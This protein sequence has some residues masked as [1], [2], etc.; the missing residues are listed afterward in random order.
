MKNFRSLLHNVLSIVM[1]MAAFHSSI[2]QTDHAKHHPKKT[3]ANADSST[4]MT[5]AAKDPGMGKK[6]AGMVG[7]MG[8]EMGEMMKEMGKP[9]SKE[10]YPSL[11]EV[12]DLSSEQ[13][14]EIKQLAN[15]QVRQGN[16]LL[17]MGLRELSGA[18]RR[19]DREAMLDANDKIQR[20][21]ILLESGLEG[22]R[23][24]SENNDP[25]VTAMQWFNREMNLPSTSHAPQ[26]HGFFGLSWFHYITML[27]LGAFAAVMIWMYFHKMQ[28]A[29][30]LI[31]K[32]TGG[33]TDKILPPDATKPTAGKGEPAAKSATAKPELAAKSSS[34]PKGEVAAKPT[35]VSTDMPPSKPNAF[36]G[37]LLVSEIFNE[38]P[39]VK[40]FRLIDSSGGKLPFNYLPGQF[41]SLT[42][43]PNGV[44]INRS[45]TMASSPT[46]RD[47][48]EITVKHEERPGVS[49][50]LHT[51]VHEGELLQLTTPSGKFT[52]T[53]NDGDSIV[54][55][56]GGVGVTPFMSTIRYLTDRSWKKDIYLLFSCKN[57]AGIIF[58]EEIGYLQKRYPNLHVMFVLSQPDKPDTP[59][60]T[61]RVTKEIITKL[62]PE[63]TK[64]RIHICG[65]EPMM[66]AVKQMLNE[67][68]VPKEN[69]KVELFA[70]PP[71]APPTSPKGD[72]SPTDPAPKEPEAPKDE[73]AKEVAKEEPGKPEVP[74]ES[75]A[76]P[77]PA[78]EPAPE[79]NG[80]APPAASS[81]SAGTA[82]ATFARSNKTAVL[83]ADKSILEASE[84]IGVNIDYQ[85]RAGTCGVCKTNL[86][87]GNV[88]MAV[89]DALTEEDK[90]QNIILACQAKATEDVSVDA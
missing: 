69:V 48:C 39:N 56:A 17:S 20:G 65:P 33:S 89:E 18:T 83:T 6:S 14:D 16:A 82:V 25:R 67:L 59:Y 41:I 8:D 19:E 87:S 90:A 73:V 75:P 22:Q 12:P 60:I 85:C 3:T 50:Y 4:A 57:E 46:H 2:A 52:F 81:E 38:T 42:V 35:A 15:D 54:L 86:I 43:I 55:I 30:A 58:R 23:A 32:L 40:T 47:Y 45:Y 80:K 88:T 61:G 76:E 5:P 36:K 1:L 26:P 34:P 29:N 31:L 53:E 74:D 77:I 72:S 64:G 21:Q 68:E 71:P 24:L 27:M 78:S 11:M 51:Q 10:L 44:P 49:H 66:D 13:I 79:E 62:V 84:D 9:S 63:I 70:S 7:G 37:T 28:R